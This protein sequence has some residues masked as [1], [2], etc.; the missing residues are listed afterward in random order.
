L[1]DEGPTQKRRQNPL[2]LE[3]KNSV[4]SGIELGQLTEE[5]RIIQQTARRFAEKEIQ[6]FAKELDESSSFPQEIYTKMAEA[7][8]FGIT[9]PLEWGGAG[10]DNQ[11]YAIVME[12]LAWGYASVADQCGLVELVATLLF[13]LGTDAQKEN[14]LPAIIQAQKKCSFALTEPGA[15]S[16]LGS[17]STRALKTTEGYRIKGRKAFIHNAPV[18]D[19]ALVLARSQEGSVGNRGL[20]IFIVESTL[21]GFS[22]GKKE[23]KMGQRASQLSDLVF[24]DCLLPPEALLGK[25]SDG[26]KNMMIVLEKGRIG[27]A[28]LSVGIARAALETSVS[29]AK[30]R[31]QFGQPI[32]KFQAIQWKLTEM[33]VD[34]FAARAM[35][36]HAATLKDKGLPVAMQ[37]SMAKLFASE[38]AVKHTAAAIQIHGGYG[39]IRDYPVERLHRD[40]MTTTIYEGTS[41]VQRIII[42]RSLLEK[43]L[44]P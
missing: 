16:D 1:A 26:F 39:Y 31:R 7:G 11:T 24:E 41:E 36:M 22:R 5:Q 12:E 29:Y 8:L 18:C 42:A 19:F 13:E 23:Q 20:S 33:A 17:I 30:E 10:T 9:I 38:M 14:Y 37:A 28:A 40:A 35:I 32:A 34:I 21:P 44:R 15:G 25:E 2:A 6:P 4:G 3:G 43:G 27:I